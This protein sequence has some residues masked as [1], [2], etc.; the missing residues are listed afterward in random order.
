MRPS[1]RVSIVLLAAGASTRMRGKDKLMRKIDG[2]PLI[3]RIARE[4]CEST[5]AEVIVVLRDADRQR[6]K[7]LA[8]FSVT[9]VNNPDWATGMASSLVAGLSNVANETDAIMVLL[10]D[11][12]DIR[13]REIDLLIQTYEV[14]S[15]EIVRASSGGIGGHPIL[16]SNTL[17]D[18]IRDLSGPNG[19]RDVIKKHAKAIQL[20]DIGDMSATT[21][22]DTPEDWAEY[23][24]KKARPE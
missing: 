1:L 19:A 12:P 14:S 4:C 9:I 24:S 3:R 15:A 10:A 16:F 17:F 20:V 18:E 2:T 6:A 8:D 21:D 11:M 7:E 13:Q 5:A 23:L 22:L